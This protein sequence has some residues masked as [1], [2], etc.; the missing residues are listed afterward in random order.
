MT[1][2]QRI[3]RKKAISPN[4][5]VHKEGGQQAGQNFVPDARD[6]SPEELNQKLQ[7]GIYGRVEEENGD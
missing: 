6:E 3:F 4:D 1:W 2:L 7:S 5:I